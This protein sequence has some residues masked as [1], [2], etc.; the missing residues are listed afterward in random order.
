MEGSRGVN[1]IDAEGVRRVNEKWVGGVNGK[2]R[3][4]NVKRGV[5]K[6]VEGSTSGRGQ[7]G[8]MGSKGSKGSTRGVKGGKE[9]SS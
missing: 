3:G 2:V 6:M 9:V 8:S 4:V 5:K 1:R 7:G